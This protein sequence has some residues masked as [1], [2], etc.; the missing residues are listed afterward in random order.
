VLAPVRLD[1]HLTVVAGTEDLAPAK[2][3]TQV[4]CFRVVEYSGLISL[5]RRSSVDGFTERRVLSYLEVRQ[6][7][8]LA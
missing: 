7:I 5:V 6:A 3:R 2:E 4:D 1:L 8:C